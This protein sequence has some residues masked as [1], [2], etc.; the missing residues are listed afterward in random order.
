DV[1]R[2]AR[3]VELELDAGKGFLETALEFLAQLGAGGNRDDDPAF[4]SCRFENF[5]PSRA[6]RL[7]ER[8]GRWEQR[9]Q[10][11]PQPPQD[12][13]FSLHEISKPKSFRAS[14]AAG[15]RRRLILSSD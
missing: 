11:D 12:A 13:N 1:T 14:A 5:L 9:R 4:F 8:R 2:A 10:R 15:S 6:A 3:D 7:P